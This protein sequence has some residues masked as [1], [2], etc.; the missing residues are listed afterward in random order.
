MIRAFI[1]FA[2]ADRRF[3][4][5]FPYHRSSNIGQLA[6]SAGTENVSRVVHASTGVWPIWKITENKP[7]YRTWETP[8]P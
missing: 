1:N 8:S 5:D 6:P 3:K 2:L 7:L 4:R